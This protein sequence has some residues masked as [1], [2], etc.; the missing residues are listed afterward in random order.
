MLG[1]LPEDV[2]TYGPQIDRLFSI[3]QWIT[4]ITFV[5]VIVLL[6]LFIIKYR[7]QG[8]RRATYTHGSTVLE[9]IW[10][11]VPAI[12]LIVLFMLSQSLWWSIKGGVPPTDFQ[13]Q[14]TAKQFNWTF[15]YP[16]PDGVLGTADDLT[17]EN[18]L[19]VPVNKI[20]R[21]SLRAQDV[22]HSFFLPNLRLKQDAVPGREIPAWFE[23]TKTG[24]YEIPCAELCG[25]GHSGM[26]GHL[27]V[28]SAEEYQRWAKEKGAS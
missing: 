1:W 8:G 15:T 2:S 22:I 6:L 23:A 12:I 25:F 5:I 14:V 7:D 11:I 28:H 18:E 13:V 24:Q 16:G 17:L 3:I 10:T 4:G 26:L 27:T 21:V 9:V 20:V 19:H